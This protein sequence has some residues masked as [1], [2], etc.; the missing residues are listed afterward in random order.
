MEEWLKKRH[1]GIHWAIHRLGHSSQGSIAW[2]EV[3]T[4]IGNH[5]RVLSSNVTWSD[6]HFEGSLGLQVKKV[7]GGYRGGYCFSDLA[8]GMWESPCDLVSALSGFHDYCLPFCSWWLTMCVPVQALLRPF[9]Q[10]LVFYF[11]M[12]TPFYLY[13]AFSH[14]ALSQGQ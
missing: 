8:R 7:L 14:L 11:S 6:I 2:T 1:C 13:E 9:S 10:I 12:E 4:A 5:P 3:L